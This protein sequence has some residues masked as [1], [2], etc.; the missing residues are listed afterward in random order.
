MHL[1]VL[2]S[3]QR[4]RARAALAVIRLVS[5]MEPDAVA[6]TSLYRPA[7][8]GRHFLRLVADVLR[9]PSEWSAGERELI[10]AV[11]SSLNQCPFCT[12]VHSAMVA[13]RLDRTLFPDQLRSWRE[14]HFEPRLAAGLELAEKVTLSPD[15][16]S[17]DDIARA[18][19]AGLSDAAII[20]VFYVAFVFNLINRVANA[21]GFDWGGAANAQRGAA[22]L[23]RMAYRVP[24]F[25]LS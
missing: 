10:A 9:G 4:L 18:H 7:Y 17:R 20:D 22:I 23:N 8:F 6:R 24:G 5:R 12:Q 11:V 1:D 2:Y 19:A 16:V 25:L 13:I 3:G 14:Q 15:Q 21:F